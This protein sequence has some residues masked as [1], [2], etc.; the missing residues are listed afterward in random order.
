MCAAI[1]AT[2]TEDMEGNWMSFYTRAANCKEA[3][4][5]EDDGDRRPEPNLNYPSGR[6]IAAYDLGQVDYYRVCTCLYGD[7][8]TSV[9]KADNGEER[10]H[11]YDGKVPGGKASDNT[12]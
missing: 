6:A 11:Y 2:A 3:L 8:K 1:V 7:D 9:L 12:K 4:D 10:C 5:N